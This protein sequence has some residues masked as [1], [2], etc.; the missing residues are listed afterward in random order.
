MKSGK[1]TSSYKTNRFMKGPEV[2]FIS[3]NLT[4][5]KYHY[6]NIKGTLQHRVDFSDTLKQYKCGRPVSVSNDGTVYVYKKQRSLKLHI[7]RLHEQEF[8]HVKTIKISNAIDKYLSSK[9][10]D[11]SKSIEDL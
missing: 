10:K 7:C 8:Q 2:D 9:A 1:M 4:D 5:N 11:E 3:I 6:F